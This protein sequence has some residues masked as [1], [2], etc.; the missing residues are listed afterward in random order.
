MPLCRSSLTQEI[1]LSSV[2]L[3]DCPNLLFDQ[4]D[5]EDADADTE[6]TDTGDC[7][8]SLFDQKDTRAGYVKFFFLQDSGG[9]VE[10]ESCRKLNNI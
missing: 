3:S 9:K 10:I 8:N 2:Q 6:D 7:P 4:K 5:K 1:N